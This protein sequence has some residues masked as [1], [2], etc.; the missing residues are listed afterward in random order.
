MK[1]WAP[2][3]THFFIEIILRHGRSP[4]N[5]LHIFR[6]PSDQNASAGLLLKNH[7][8]GGTQFYHDVVSIY[9]SIS[10]YS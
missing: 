8:D 2:K 5:L 6:I 4:V 1:I 10:E 9:N 7:G 3:M